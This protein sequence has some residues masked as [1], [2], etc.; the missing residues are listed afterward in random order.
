MRIS[1]C[2]CCPFDPRYGTVIE[3]E[4]WVERYEPRLVR[5]V[6]IRDPSLGTV[7]M[8]STLDDYRHRDKEDP[9]SPVLP[10]DIHARWPELKT[11]MHFTV[12]KWIEHEHVG[13]SAPSYQTP[14]ECLES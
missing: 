14:S 8:A 5:R 11:D 1:K 13:P 2:C 9:T 7:L 3:T 10:H 6:I 4:Y 12:L